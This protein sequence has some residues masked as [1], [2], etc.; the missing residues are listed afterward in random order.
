MMKRAYKPGVHFPAY[1]AGVGK[2]HCKDNS[3]RHGTLQINLT[4]S[5]LPPQLRRHRA[6]I[7]QESEQG[8]VRR[9]LPQMLTP[10]AAEE[11]L[12]AFKDRVGQR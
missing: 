4:S 10:L 9:K 6:Q 1:S 11:N 5:D 8:S 7:P 3:Q 12:A 2:V